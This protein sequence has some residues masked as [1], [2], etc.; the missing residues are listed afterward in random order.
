M[1]DSK[2][3]R[4][5]NPETTRKKI[6]KAAAKE[7]AQKGFDGARVDRIAVLAGVNKQL[8]YHYFGSKDD[9]FTAVLEN[10][11]RNFR[12]CEAALDL[13][14]LKADE[15]IL[16]LVE[17]TWGYYLEH[18]EFIRLLNSENQLEARHLKASPQT[19]GINAGHLS[20]MQQ[21]LARGRKEGTVRRGL[22]AMQLN[23]NIAALGFFYLINRH[24]L[25]TVFQRDLGARA[26]LA[27]RLNVMKDVIAR[28]IRA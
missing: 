22:D 27:E 20:R 14:D 8:L 15:A 13:D 5:R 18:P 23:V 12:E 19:A 11:Y 25:S 10:A 26:A 9:L 21:L 28:W 2:R 24:T 17:F 3:V 16:K 7:F 6:L 1:D 4:T